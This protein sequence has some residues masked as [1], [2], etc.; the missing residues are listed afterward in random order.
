MKKTVLAGEMYLLSNGAATKTLAVLAYVVERNVTRSCC[1]SCCI[2]SSL[3]RGASYPW[4]V[5]SHQTYF[6][7]VMACEKSIQDGRIAVGKKKK[8][9]INIHSTAC[10]ASLTLSNHQLIPRTI[11]SQ[12][13][14]ALFLSSPSPSSQ[15]SVLLY[16]SV[17]VV[18]ISLSDG[19]SMSR[20]HTPCT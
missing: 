1:S 17:S 6:K 14:Y 3:S 5:R 8:K 7:A 12:V 11:P 13:N 2:P 20:F 10:L 16:Q 4:S 9:L 19:N 15:V 18:A